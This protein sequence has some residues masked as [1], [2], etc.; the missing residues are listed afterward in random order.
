MTGDGVVT[1]CIPAYQAQA[2]IDR[3][4]RCAR[5]QTYRRSAS[6]VAIDARTTAP[7]RFCRSHA[8]EDDRVEVH[9]HREQQGWFGNVNSLLDT[10][11]SEY[12]FIYFH[13]DLIEPTYCEQLVGAL[14]RRPDAASAHCDVILDSPGG[15][16]LRK[17]CAYEGSA[18]ERLLT[19]FVSPDRGALLRSM[20]RRSSPAGS[21]RMTLQ[22][23]QYEMALVAA[24][25]GVHVAEPLYRRI[26]AAGRRPD[27]RLATAAVRALRRG[28]AGTTSTMARELIDD[29]RPSTEERELLEFGLAV[30]ITNRLRTLEAQHAA[31]ALTPLEDVLGPGATLRLPSAVDAASRRADRGLH[32]GAAA[33]RARDREAGTTDRPAELARVN[34][35]SPC[36]A[37][38]SWARP[39]RS[40]SPAAAPR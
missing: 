19:H 15:E 8:R 23:A 13:D 22:G 25:P 39:P 38:G 14:R 9:A 30:Y 20:V 36:S 18:A 2:F 17:G 12:S 7:R 5:D 4:L 16:S 34:R 6:L 1:V 28:R 32:Q 27:R 35:R 21:L 31:P 26:V 10:V 3:T 37:P 33:G 11:R 40:T 24:G 29:V